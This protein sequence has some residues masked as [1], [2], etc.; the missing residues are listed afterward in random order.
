MASS[1]SVNV[2]WVG[3]DRIPVVVEL[4]LEEAPPGSPRGWI[5][6]VFHGVEWLFGLF[7]LLVGLAVLAAI[8]LGQFLALG[9][10]LEVSGRVARTGRFR[11]GFIGIRTAARW[12][13]I[14]VAGFIL[15]LPLYFLSLQAQAAQI[16]DPAG[17]IARQWQ[18]WLAIVTTI[19][20][21][22]ALAA[23]VRGGRFRDFLR[24]FNLLWLVRRVWRG[25]LFRE[26][27][28]R[29]WT[30]LVELRLP[31]YFWLGVR[32]FVGALVWLVL[33]LLLLAQGHRVPALGILGGLL[34]A[35]VVM[36]VPFLQVRFARDNRLAAFVEC[37]AVRMAF[38]RA[39]L[40]FAV[41]LWVHL[42]FAIP[43]YLLKIEV[44]PRELVFLEG[45]LF[46]LLMFPARLLGGW[47]IA[48]GCRRPTPRWWGVRW[49]SRIA[50]LPVLGA[51]V[52]VVFLSQH[53]GWQGIG[54]LYEQHAFLLPVPFV[55]W[56]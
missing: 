1:S 56:P 28:D 19:V 27:R 40:A 4:D 14:A 33:P 16:I 53:L 43:L 24:P 36:Y 18:L 23:V 41:A 54:S 11:D 48:R 15:W 52:F 9:Y 7:A 32:G 51:Y 6:T 37:R 26:A 38:R 50:V 29:L 2:E 47:A 31:Y 8:P 55:T 25:G 45:L 44:I 39:P 10:L 17:P 30:A 12:G 3:G 42:S 20:T 49:L 13:K 22:H 34:L 46:L 5:G 35:A 21:L